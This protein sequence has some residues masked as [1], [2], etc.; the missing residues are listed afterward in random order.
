MFEI[1]YYGMLEFY[2]EDFNAFSA[3]I[4]GPPDDTLNALALGLLG[5]ADFDF[6]DDWVV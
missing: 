2:N 6:I 5:K 3:T 4:G 1:A